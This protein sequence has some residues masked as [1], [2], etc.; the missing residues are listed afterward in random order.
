MDQP[1]DIARYT[2]VPGLGLDLGDSFPAWLNSRRATLAQT[3]E[4]A[5]AV[6]DESRELSM[7]ELGQ[8][9]GAGCMTFVDSCGCSNNGGGGSGGTG[10]YGGGHGGGHGH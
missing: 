3:Q 4:L 9:I 1:I 6:T 8:V 10:G 2:S 5:Q 7:D